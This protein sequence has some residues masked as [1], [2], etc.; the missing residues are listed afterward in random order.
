MIRN[1]WER[2]CAMAAPLTPKLQAKIRI[3]SKIMF[4]TSPATAL[5]KRR[6]NYSVKK[7]SCCSSGMKKRNTSEVPVAYKGVLVSLK[8]RKTPCIAK[9][10]R[11]AGA[12]SERSVKYLCA[13]KSIGEPCSIKKVL[14][15]MIIILTTKRCVSVGAYRFHTHQAQKWFC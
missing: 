3:G 8:P 5:R 6:Y 14:S 13:G 12:P 11:T 9:E 15:Q 2:T 1:Y 10:I 4:A 7:R